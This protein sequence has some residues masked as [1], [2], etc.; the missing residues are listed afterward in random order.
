MGKFAL[1]FLSIFTI[2]VLYYFSTILFFSD[3]NQKNLNVFNMYTGV[4]C[5]L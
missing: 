3:L 5:T 1:A 2:S 4:P